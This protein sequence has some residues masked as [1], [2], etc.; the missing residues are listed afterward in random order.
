MIRNETESWGKRDYNKNRTLKL[1]Q[2]RARKV[3][4]NQNAQSWNKNTGCL[5]KSETQKLEQSEHQIPEL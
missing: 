5:I 1:E 4:T 2:S 3:E